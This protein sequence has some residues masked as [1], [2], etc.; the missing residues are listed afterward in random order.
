[1]RRNA[2]AQQRRPP[3]SSAV[4]AVIAGV[5][6]VG[7][8]AGGWTALLPWDLSELNANGQQ[9]TG[10]G[11][12]YI[13]RILLVAAVYMGF[14]ALVARWRSP[15]AVPFVASAALSWAALFAWRASVST[16]AGANLWLLMFMFVV[17][18]VAVGSVVVAR[19][20]ASRSAAARLRD[21]ES[22]G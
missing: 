4:A 3:P 11:D 8:T 7:V 21:S 15:M 2:S 22:R 19:W 13:P 16:V 20:L 12:D 1:M 9:V 18:P 14:G 10:G 6:G 17:L 5:A